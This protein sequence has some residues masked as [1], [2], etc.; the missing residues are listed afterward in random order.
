MNSPSDVTPRYQDHL[1]LFV[2]G[3]PSKSNPLEILDHFLQFG[4]VQLHKLGS[5]KKGSRV[6]H[7]N[8]TSNTRRG[9]CILQALD[10]SS[11]HNI[12]DCSAVPFQGR[13]LAISRFRQG[14]ELA[15]YNE[16]VNSRRII[17][18]KVPATVD[19]QELR[20]FIELRFGAIARIYLY[21]AE[22]IQKALKKVSRRRTHTYS[23][24]F[25]AIRSAERASTV[26]YLELPESSSPVLIERY[27]R[28]GSSQQVDSN[29]QPSTPNQAGGF[30]S[31]F[32]F[33]MVS[34]DGGWDCPLWRAEN[35]H[36]KPHKMGRQEADLRK[37]RH[38]DLITINH[39]L[40]PTARNYHYSRV[41]SPD[42]F[43][44]QEERTAVRFNF[45][46]KSIIN[47]G[48]RNGFIK[49]RQERSSRERQEHKGDKDF[50]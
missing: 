35:R 15:A 50:L 46:M 23:V 13:T 31:V 18:K 19:L 16:F 8:P 45:T 26:G 14:E 3:I 32:P 25:E 30:R 39:S 42:R 36:S 41:S 20:C 24:E 9:F 21:E 7:V 49:R 1:M 27:N 5:S 34:A 29:S 37:R 17:V 11:Y 28:K 43:L 22:S 2:T 6:L 12:L 33:Q 47:E 40:K 10:V 4:R 38:R 48:F 44:I